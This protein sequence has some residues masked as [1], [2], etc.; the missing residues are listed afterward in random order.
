MSME[1]VVDGGEVWLIGLTLLSIQAIP[2]GS[3]FNIFNL[4]KENVFVIYIYCISLSNIMSTVNHE[5]WS[6]K[7]SFSGR[8]RYL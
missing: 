3:D 5:I 6:A 7:A 8:E 2:R 1:A 4:F